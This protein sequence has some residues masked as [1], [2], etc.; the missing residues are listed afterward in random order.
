M[1]GSSPRWRGSKNTDHDGGASASQKDLVS[2]AIERGLHSADERYLLKIFELGR[3]VKVIFVKIS[4][5]VVWILF[6]HLF[7]SMNHY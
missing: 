6:I 3:I 7:I 1:G 4:L 2:Q 5:E